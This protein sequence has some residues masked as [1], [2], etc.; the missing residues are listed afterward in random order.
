MY[1][2]YIFMYTAA[3][4][5]VRIFQVFTGGHAEILTKSL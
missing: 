4:D 5:I 1:Y 3:G 2:I